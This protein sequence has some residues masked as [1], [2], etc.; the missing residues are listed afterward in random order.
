[1]TSRLVG[2]MGVAIGVIAAFIPAT[3]APASSG[4]SSAAQLD[5][6]LRAA[7]AL[8]DEWV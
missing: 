3:D 2:A 6:A 1:M 7:D 8:V 5:T 4:S